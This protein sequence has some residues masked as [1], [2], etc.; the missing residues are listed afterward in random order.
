MSDKVVITNDI[1]KDYFINYIKEIKDAL[2][3]YNNSKDRNNFPRG[4]NF[5]KSSNIN[6]KK[7]KEGYEE[8]SRKI[9]DILNNP[10]KDD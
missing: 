3:V 10:N 6:N 1:E 8:L 2:K 5:F 7:N 9:N 4:Y